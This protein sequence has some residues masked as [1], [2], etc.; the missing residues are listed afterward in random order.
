MKKEIKFRAKRL[1]NG[2]YA[3]GHYWETPC[4]MNGYSE[5][6]SQEMICY[7]A[8]TEFLGRPCV[9]V[10]PETVGQFIGEKDI[11][12]KEIYEGD[13]IM[14]DLAEGLGQP[15]RNALKKIVSRGLGN[16]DVNVKIIKS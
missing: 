6:P 9:E 3:Y 16:W 10:D 1:D 11:Y 4:E 2:E 14:Y 15:R 5:P 12:G 8:Q 13:E 7:I